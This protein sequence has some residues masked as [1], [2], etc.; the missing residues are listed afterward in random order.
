MKLYEQY[1]LE[2][3]PNQVAA[4]TMG[5]LGLATLASIIRYKKQTKY[6][7]HPD[8]SRFYN[9]C[10]KS[11]IEL[12]TKKYKGEKGGDDIGEECEYICDKRAKN[13]FQ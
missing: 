12:L 7:K 1:L 2:I 8:Y 11:C 13:K 3:T 4:G 6:K 10:K 9:Q 5:T